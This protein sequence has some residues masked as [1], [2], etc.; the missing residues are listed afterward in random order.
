MKIEKFEKFFESNKRNLTIEDLEDLLVDIQDLLGKD[1][2][3]ISVVLGSDKYTDFE[4]IE[5]CDMSHKYTDFGFL[6][7]IRPNFNNDEDI[8]N[9]SEKLSE[10]W[11][12]V[13]TF[14]KRINYIF[15][16]KEVK[17]SESSDTNRN[18]E[19]IVVTQITEYTILWTSNYFLESTIYNYN[20]K[21]N[22][23][24]K[25]EGN[26]FSVSIK[27]E[28]VHQSYSG[29]MTGI[30]YLTNEYINDTW[31]EKNVEYELIETEDSYVF[32]NFKIKNLFE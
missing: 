17:E 5:Y 16:V 2:V 13:N 21:A 25:N 29:D 3:N 4:E 15:S 23:L 12:L 24:N 6:I 19:L 20:T 28:D 18:I 27:K 11:S 22:V 8:L 31:G 7:Y 14:V 10:F 30:E 9:K 26:Q 1:N 32:K